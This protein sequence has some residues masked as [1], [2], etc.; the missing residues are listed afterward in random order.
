MPQ[1]ALAK[2]A[3][4]KFALPPLALISSMQRR[5]CARHWKSPATGRHLQYFT[6]CSTLLNTAWHVPARTFAQFAC[7]V[8]SKSTGT[9]SQAGCLSDPVY[10]TSQ[11]LCGGLN[12]EYQTCVLSLTDTSASYKF[13]SFQIVL[14]KVP[15]KNETKPVACA[16]FNF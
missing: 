4:A 5:T 11:Q 2:F 7:S 10:Q 15:T 3:L 16:P 14:K 1:F 8:C 9:A 6:S 13:P 12:P